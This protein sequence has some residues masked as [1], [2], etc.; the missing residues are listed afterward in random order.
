VLGVV[1]IALVVG[2]TAGAFAAG[3]VG[4]SPTPAPSDGPTP[5]PGPTRTSGKNEKK[6]AG[7]KATA[8]EIAQSAQG[9]SYN[10]GEWVHPEG[11]KYVRGQVLR[12]T[13]KPGKAVP[14][15]PGKLALENAENVAPKAITRADT[16]TEAEKKA[17]IRRKN[18]TPTSA[19]Q[20]GSHL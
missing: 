3:A 7:Q 18:L 13:A 19:P 1:L 2:V 10:K 17:E 9:W 15:P 14:Q 8:Q 16:Q 12:T 5:T 11:Y 4:G 20:T 6:G